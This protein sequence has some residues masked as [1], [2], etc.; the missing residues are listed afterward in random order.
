MK[1]EVKKYF[2]D[3]S[4]QINL[5]LAMIFNRVGD[6]HG[7]FENA[8]THN[9]Y[10]GLIKIMAAARY[11]EAQKFAQ[12]KSAL[13]DA[14]QLLDSCLSNEGQKKTFLSNQDLIKAAI[15]TL[16]SVED[17]QVKEVL[18]YYKKDFNTYIIKG[19]QYP[20]ENPGQ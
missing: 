14:L 17:E 4:Q 8:Y 20:P 15:K 11:S 2:T 7:A 16:E 6:M 5:E 1:K 10:V 3:Y 19:H 18:F 9:D 12:S 13:S